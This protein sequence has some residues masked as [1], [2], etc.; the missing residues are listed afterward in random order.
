M[1][2][3]IITAVMSGLAHT[4]ECSEGF[5]GQ[6]CMDVCQCQNGASCDFIT[7]LCNCTIGYIG[8]FCDMSKSLVIKH[9]NN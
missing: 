9:D 2:T 3:M 7:G 8:R 5:Y 1:L 4:L 6:D